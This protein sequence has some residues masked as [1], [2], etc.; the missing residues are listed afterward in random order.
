MKNKTI[1]RM[2]R[3]GVGEVQITLYN[4]ADHRDKVITLWRR[5]FGYD[6]ARNSPDLVIDKKIA[7]DDGLFFVAISGNEVVGTGMA[8]YDGHRG[9]IYSLA[10]APDLRG[11]GIGAALL[12]HAEDR[13]ADL[14]CVKINLQVLEGNEGAVRFYL[15]NGYAAENRI[16]MG[17]EIS[18]NIHLQS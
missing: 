13:L 5:V 16:S 8:G 7:I 9:W 6:T 18:E 15:A 14:G 11:H 10:V 12:K 3:E 1:D 2:P 17:K 4:N